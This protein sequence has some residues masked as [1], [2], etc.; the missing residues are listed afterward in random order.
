MGLWNMSQDLEN[1][2]KY[3]GV[4]SSPITA[5][6]GY[7]E[8]VW[9][10]ACGVFVGKSHICPRNFPQLL[11]FIFCQPQRFVKMSPLRRLAATRACDPCQ[12][13]KVKCDVSTEAT[14]SLIPR[15]QTNMET[16]TGDL[17]KLPNIWACLPLYN[18]PQKAGT[19][20]GPEVIL[21]TTKCNACI[22]QQCSG[23]FVGESNADGEYSG[24]TPWRSRKHDIANIGWNGADLC[25]SVRTG[26]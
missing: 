5:A 24:F 3:N 18:C 17:C 19:Q 1:S 25:I 13:R 11:L 7:G 12:R 9:S 21:R 22:G 2:Q 16:D 20:K 15:D 4:Q 26:H 14:R 8:M 6:A 23:F 10:L